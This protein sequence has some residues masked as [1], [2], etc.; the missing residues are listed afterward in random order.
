MPSLSQASGSRRAYA[1]RHRKVHTKAVGTCLK[2]VLA[3]ILIFGS[4]GQLDRLNAQ[5]IT[6][7]HRDE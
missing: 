1:G 3:S 7:A 2:I 4:V 5:P 6:T